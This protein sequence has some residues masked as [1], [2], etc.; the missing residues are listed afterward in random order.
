M[1]QKSEQKYL[2]D[3]VS[4]AGKNDENIHSRRN[5]GIGIVNEIMNILEKTAF[6]KYFFE[7]ALLLRNSLLWSSM[8]INCEAWVNISNKNLRSLEQV[9]EMLLSRILDCAGN[10]SNAMKYLELGIYPIR[11]EIYR[12]TVLFLQYIRKEDESSMINKVLQAT[13]RQKMILLLNANQL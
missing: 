5:R 8:L 7:V 2:G 12:R 10:T 6:G 4:K 3:I 11:F 9:D 1:S 13:I